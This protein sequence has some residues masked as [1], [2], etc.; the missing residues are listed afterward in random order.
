MTDLAPVY[1][2]VHRILVQYA[3]KL[4]T[5][6]GKSCFNFKDSA[7]QLFKGTA[8]KSYERQGFV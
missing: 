2:A 1:A 5:K 3:G 7:P 4:D 6:H 8:Y